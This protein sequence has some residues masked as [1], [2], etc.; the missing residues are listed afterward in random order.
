MLKMNLKQHT[1]TAAFVVAAVALLGAALL[2]SYA[3][4]STSNL[5]D[6]TTVSANCTISTATAAFGTYDP[7]S[8]NASSAPDGTGTVT[9]TCTNGSSA[10]VTL[11]QGAN[12]DTGSTDAAPLRRLK[13]SG[14]NYLS[15]SLYSDS[16]R[17]TVWGNTAGTG[18]VAH[19]GDGMATA[20]TVYGWIAAGQNKPAAS[21]SDTVVA[22]VTF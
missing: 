17:T 4:T 22:T 14:T 12:A 9:V 10:T 8:A 3:G 1:R 18:V 5:S 20:L 7:V 6:T 16:A 21:Y 13:D 15:Y 19:T 2:S 11:D